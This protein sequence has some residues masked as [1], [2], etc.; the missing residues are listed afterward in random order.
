MAGIDASDL[1]HY[2]SG[3]LEPVLCDAASLNHAVLLVGYDQ[4]D[5]GTPYWRIK[6]SWGTKWGELGFGRVI[7]GE[8]ACGINAEVTSA[9][10]G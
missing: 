7:R 8:G 9:V 3:V 2:V 5:E 1:Q 10:L 6:N 4:T